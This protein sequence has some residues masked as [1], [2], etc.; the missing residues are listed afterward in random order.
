MRD[1]IVSLTLAV[2][3]SMQCTCDQMQGAPPTH[4]LFEDD[5]TKSYHVVYTSS[6]KRL[7]IT[8]TLFEIWNRTARE[9]RANSSTRDP[10][11]WTM[12]LGWSCLYFCICKTN[13]ICETNCQSCK[14]KCLNLF[15][16]SNLT[17]QGGFAWGSKIHYLLL[18]L[19]S[20]DEDHLRTNQ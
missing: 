3:C 4:R 9:G 11:F 5:S 7:H 18:P 14:N 8:W 17:N 16:H 15:R 1:K 10:L 19:Q 6:Q 2:H 12:L 20:V 13:C